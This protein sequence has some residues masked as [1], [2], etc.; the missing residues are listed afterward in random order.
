MT[1]V[2]VHVLVSSDLALSLVPGWSSGSFPAYHVVS[3]F[4][5]G[6]ATTVI[7]LWLR[8]QRNRETFHACARLL[9]ALALLWFYFTW[10]ELLT[11]WYGQTP[12][13][14]DLLSLLMFGATLPLFVAAASLCCIVPIAL[15]IW[16]PIRAS[17]A[18]TTAIAC[19]ILVGLFL[20]R[21]R[22]YVAAWSVAGPV[23]ERFEPIAALPMPGP[24]ELALAVILPLAT[25]G[26]LIGALR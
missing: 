3:A 5:G 11:Y 25:I 19:A 4:Q 21:V 23:R 17:A 1:F 12:A 15:L 7:A 8:K 9:L 20:D 16:N 10:S 2:L 13:E 26:L 18:A 24:P 14:L 6:V 22:I